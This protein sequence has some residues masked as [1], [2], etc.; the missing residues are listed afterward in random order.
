MK[1]LIR[2]L[3]D[4]Y[5]V[6]KDATWREGCYYINHQNRE[7]NIHQTEILAVKEDEREGKVICKNCGAIIDNNPE[8]IEKH[9]ATQEASRNCLTCDSVATYGDRENCKT[10]YTK[11][12]NGTYHQCTTYDTKLRCKLSMWNYVDINSREAKTICKFNQCRQRGVNK[13]TDFFMEHPGAFDTQ[14]TVDFLLQKGFE[15][16]G[17]Y[18]G[19][20]YYDLKLR[21]ALKACVNE[22]GVVD[23][24]VVKHRD[25]A[26]SAYY[27]DKY[28]KLFF[29]NHY[30]YSESTPGNM[31]D[32]KHKNAK[33]K[34][35]AL[36]KEANNK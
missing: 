18:S 13:A 14:L 12:E 36:Y 34:I 24:F 8:A 7:L 29:E 11:N 25:Y 5:Y 6:W 10:T 3:D 9:F 4:K 30:T 32:T 31:S 23:H 2:R 15:Y 21:G 1:I 17:Y 33:D 28:D 27:S 35:A 19:S 16:E 20:F 22:M 26:Y